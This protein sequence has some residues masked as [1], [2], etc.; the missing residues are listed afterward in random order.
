[1]CESAFVTGE[2]PWKRRGAGEARRA[3]RPGI[4]VRGPGQA[5]NLAGCQRVAAVAALLRGLPPR[6]ADGP[7][8]IWPWQSRAH[9]DSSCAQVGDVWL[10]CWCSI[11]LGCA[12]RADGQPAQSPFASVPAGWP[13]GGEGARL[14][15]LAARPGS[16][17]RG[18]MSVKGCRF[19]ITPTPP[20]NKS[21]IIMETIIV[22]F[23]V[24]DG[25]WRGQ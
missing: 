8:I 19:G 10:D 14:P 7:L 2:V 22:Q 1:M 11:V 6:L 20:F 4:A 3:R 23:A 15:V 12:V 5:G 21:T 17:S 24:T 9:S 25:C 18:R 16:E 13:N